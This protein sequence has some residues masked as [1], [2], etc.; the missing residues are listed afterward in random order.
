MRVS[1][2][3][4]HVY[5]KDRYRAAKWFEELLGFQILKDYEAWAANEGPLSLS[6]DGGHT[7]IALFTAFDKKP[8]TNYA[9]AF[10]LNRDDF[11]QFLERSISMKVKNYQ[12]EL[13]SAKDIIDHQLAHSIYFQDPDGNHYEVTCYEV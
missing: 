7:K 10:K 11:N 8:N 12:G 4:V 9:L 3:H 13:L 6:S 5:V 2:D 1:L